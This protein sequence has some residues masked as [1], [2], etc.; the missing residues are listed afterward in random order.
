MPIIAKTA[1]KTLTENTLAILCVNSAV[2][3]ATTQPVMLVPRIEPKITGA[4]CLS[5]MILPSHRPTVIA[6]TAEDD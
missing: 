1:L 6:L 2:E 3:Y 5:F 4:A